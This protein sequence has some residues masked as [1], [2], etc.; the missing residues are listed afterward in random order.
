MQIDPSSP[1]AERIVTLRP[2]VPDAGAPAGTDPPGA[3]DGPD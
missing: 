1:F 2:S 3:V